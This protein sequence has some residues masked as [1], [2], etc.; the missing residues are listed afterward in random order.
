VLRALE[1]IAVRLS[2]EI[3]CGVFFFGL[4]TLNLVAFQGHKRQQ[5]VYVASLQL[6]LF[7]ESSFRLAGFDLWRLLAAFVSVLADCEA[8]FNLTKLQQALE[9]GIH[10]T[11]FRV[12]GKTD[13]SKIGLDILSSSIVNSTDRRLKVLSCG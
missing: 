2:S 13:S 8:P 5:R 6:A 12:V 4:V 10:H 11:A 9:T 7:L 3:Y 1:S